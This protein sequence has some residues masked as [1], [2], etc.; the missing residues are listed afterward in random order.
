MPASGG[1]LRELLELRGIESR[2]TTGGTR[3]AWSRASSFLLLA[4]SSG[5][6][7]VPIEIWHVPLEG[8]S[9]TRLTH[10]LPEPSLYGMSLHPDG[11]TVA[12]S[13][14]QP[15]RYEVWKLVG[16]VRR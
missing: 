1:P 12:L 11:R 2:Y 7:E 8:G 4:R 16:T 6:T 14:G 9:S 15:S 3:I 5:R 13:L 10:S